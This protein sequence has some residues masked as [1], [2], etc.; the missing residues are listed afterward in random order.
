MTNKVFGLFI[1][2]VFALVLALTAVSA[3]IVL[4]PTTQSLNVTSGNTPTEIT[5]CTTIGNPGD[6]EVKQIDFK[7][8]GLVSSHATFGEDDTWFPFEEIE[9]EI[10]LENNGD[11]NVDDVSVEWGLWNVQTNQWVIDLDDEDELN[12][13]DGD[14][15]TLTVTF[16]VD[17]N[18]DVD[19]DELTDG[20]DYRLYVIAT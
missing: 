15:E 10:E 13:K 3:T 4:N 14:S 1:V 12:V 18:L 5:T 9:V 7:N 16:T 17:D 20:S 19:L 6:L 2:G 8:N 11:E